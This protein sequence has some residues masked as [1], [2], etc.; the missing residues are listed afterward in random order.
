[1]TRVLSWGDS[2][3][4]FAA[5]CTG[6]QKLAGLV[7]QPLILVDTALDADAAIE[8]LNERCYGSARRWPDPY[9][10]VRHEPGWN[11]WR[12]FDLSS[13]PCDTSSDPLGIRI[14]SGTI[15]VPLPQKV[16]VSEFRAE[17]RGVMRHLRL[18][19]VVI[20]PSFLAERRNNHLDV[21]MHPRY[22]LGTVG[23]VRSAT[24]ATDLYALDPAESVARLFWSVVAARA[25][26]GD[27]RQLRWR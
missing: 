27:A 11:D 23:D 7:G 24:L 14:V 12:L 17:L 6:L 9:E 26:A 13:Q 22:T 20:A 10:S 21:V 5:S 16:P 19:E 4:V 8:Q 25:A 18:Q 15:R 1:M 3:A 2:I